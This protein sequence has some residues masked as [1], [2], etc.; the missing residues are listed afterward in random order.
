MRGIRVAKPYAQALYDAATEQDLLDHTVA[1]ANQLIGLSEASEAFNQFV[2]DPIL[3]PQFK[4]ETFERLFS[5]TLNPLTLNFLRLISS[6]Q[7]ERF[8]LA[9]LKEFL[10]IVDRKAGR[11]VA[12]V[13]SFTA[14][15]NAQQAQLKA[16][17]GVYSGKEVRLRMEVDSSLKGGFIARMG[18]TIFDGS[19]ATQLQRMQRLLARG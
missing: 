11:I 4:S 1:D 18:D 15:T 17:L 3:A 5:D 7:R 19:V 12:H 13:A 6:K 16:K 9:I 2:R 8:L 10:D 14:L